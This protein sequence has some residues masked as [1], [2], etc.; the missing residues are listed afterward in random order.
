MPHV[1][2]SIGIGRADMRRL[3]AEAVAH[4]DDFLRE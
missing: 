4:R 1:V 3:L 2:F